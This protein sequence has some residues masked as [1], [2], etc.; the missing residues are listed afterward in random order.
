MRMR[1]RLVALVITAAC[2]SPQVL[3]GG[4]SAALPLAEPAATWAPRE[5][6][7]NS[8]DPDRHPGDAQL[9]VDSVG[10]VTA[11]W[12][13]PKRS[14]F[15]VMASRMTGSRWG[16]VWGIGSVPSDEYDSD[17]LRA[18][19]GPG[20]EVVVAWGAGRSSAL[21]VGVSRFAAG[22]WSTHVLGSYPNSSLWGMSATADASGVTVAWQVAASG[23]STATIH[24]SSVRTSTPAWTD[25]VV[26]DD[27]ARYL[28][29]MQVVRDGPESLRAVWANG[30]NV[31]SAQ[32]SPAGWGVR[33]TIGS[34]LGAGDSMVAAGAV[35]GSVLVAWYSRFGIRTDGGPAGVQA[36]QRTAA[37]W[38][39]PTD[40]LVD[41]WGQMTV[42]GVFTGFGR[43]PTVV[44]THVQP[45]ADPIREAAIWSGATWTSYAQDLGSPLAAL[46]P[47]FAVGDSLVTVDSLADCYVIICAIQR[48]SWL[49]SATFS[50]GTWS[51]TAPV[52]GPS[53]TIDEFAGAV[54]P[55]GTLWVLY[56]GRP[57]KR[58]LG[59]A[60]LR[61]SAGAWSAP[62]Q[63]IDP[64]R[65]RDRVEPAPPVFA[66]DGTVTAVGTVDTAVVASRL[67]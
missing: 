9:V 55:D 20:N 3:A 19:V 45:K 5:I 40:V 56:G 29:A 62:Q 36:V 34:G 48:R 63:I 7:W 50:A 31:V 39:A 13:V 2:L 53:G 25:P 54:A 42:Q 24:A 27:A 10:V 1:A 38:S 59:F 16:K 12:T 17:Y 22:A 15:L 57:T 67:R 65:S 18:V 35:D 44:L 6:V 8:P 64:F 52:S 47:V 37:G 14:G 23:T 41:S 11:V 46:G 58:T 4:P 30:G 60:A 49:A 51:P 61:Y 43:V 32:A 28:P 21:R 26:L 66:P 33:E